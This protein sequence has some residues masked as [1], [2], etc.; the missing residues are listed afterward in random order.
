MSIKKSIPFRPRYKSNGS[1]GIIHTLDCTHFLKIG[2]VVA[3]GGVYSYYIHEGNI[4]DKEK[5]F[6][7]YKKKMNNP[8]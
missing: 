2:F 1:L 3:G 6:Y 8:G 4:S 7:A 5:K